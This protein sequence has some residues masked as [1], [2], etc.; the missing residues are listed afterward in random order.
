MFPQGGLLQEAI[1]ISGYLLE[2]VEGESSKKV[3]WVALHNV[4]SPFNLRRP[5]NP[6]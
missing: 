2:N 3:A 1:E 5:S 4:P 6:S